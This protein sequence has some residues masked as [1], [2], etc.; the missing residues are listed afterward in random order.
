MKNFSFV[1][2]EELRDINGGLLGGAAIGYI[3]G[4]CVGGIVAARVVTDPDVKGKPG[5]TK[6]MMTAF[7]ASVV[8]FTAAG[9]LLPF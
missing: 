3:V 8:S 9:C 5:Q 7:T 4:V 6:A 1:S 2:K